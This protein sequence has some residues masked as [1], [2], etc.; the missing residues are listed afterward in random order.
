[1]FKRIVLVTKK[2]PLE[3][4]LKVRALGQVEHYLSTRGE[5]IE[6]Y[7]A[8]NDQYHAALDILRPALPTDIEVYELDRERV[9]GFMFRESDLIIAVGPDGLLANVAKYLKDQQPILGVN[10]DKERIDGVLMRFSPELAVQ[11]I[12][13]IMAG[14]F[15][16]DDLTLAKVTTNDKQE[17]YAVN[18]FLIGRRDQT[19]ARYSLTFEGQ[20]ERQSSSG[21]LVSTG[22]GST[23]WMTSLYTSAKALMENSSGD[24]DH[25]DLPVPFEWDEQYLLFAVRE[26]FPSKYTGTTMLSGEIYA[27][28]PLVVTS[29]MPEGGVIFSD[30]IPSNYI[31]FNS[32]TTATITVA[33][34]TAKLIAV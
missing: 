33:D 21:I 8:T 6:E 5:S 28:S 30:G 9:A 18:D 19:S 2:T 15:R 26:G 13:G 32:G 10:P 25:D 22:V 14:K 3:L 12:D 34:R 4:L 7:R 11:K 27:D 20:T 24:Q 29:E 31:E 16:T 17:L 23:G 1:M